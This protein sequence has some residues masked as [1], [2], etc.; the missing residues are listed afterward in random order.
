MFPFVFFRH[1]I[2]ECEIKIDIPLEYEPSENYQGTLGHK[3]NH[4][5]DPSSRYKTIETARYIFIQRK[6]KIVVY[7]SQLYHFLDLE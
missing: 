3:V 2:Q 7:L 5:F 6:K 1:Q 4:K